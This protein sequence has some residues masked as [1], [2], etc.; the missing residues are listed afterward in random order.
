MT[1]EETLKEKGKIGDELMTAVEEVQAK[2]NQVAKKMNQ[3]QD[4][5]AKY[6]KLAVKSRVNLKGTEKLRKAEVY[7]ELLA[8][9]EQLVNQ[10]Q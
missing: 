10:Q 2:R 7:E 4:S 6:A 5:I 8:S 3:L 9:Y 1:F